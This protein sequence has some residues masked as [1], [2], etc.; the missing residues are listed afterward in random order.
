MNDFKMPKLSEIGEYQNNRPQSA[1]AR[2]RVHVLHPDR[3]LCEKI[4]LTLRLE[5]FAVGFSFD[6]AD[7]VHSTDHALPRVLVTAMTLD[8]SNTLEVIRGSFPR[9]SF[10]SVIVIEENPTTEQVVTAMKQGAADVFSHPFDLERLVATVRQLISQHMVVLPEMP[11][12]TTDLRLL[13]LAALT[14]RQ[15]EILNLLLEGMSSKEIGYT[16]SLSA[17]TVEGHRS[18]ILEKMDAKNSSDLMRRILA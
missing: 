8:G 15:V 14:T 5:G 13:K 3:M 1:M 18:R 4:A 10:P 9:G 7:F 11:E 16:L 12:A 17:R 6:W 2:T